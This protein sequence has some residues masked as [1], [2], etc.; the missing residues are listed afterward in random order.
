VGFCSAKKEILLK[1]SVRKIIQAVPVLVLLLGIA[2]IAHAVPIQPVSYDMPNG[3]GISVGGEYNYW[4]ENYT[5]SGDKTVDGAP[6]TGGLG[7]LT[8]GIIAT[9][10]WEWT[11]VSGNGQTQ[12]DLYVGWTW[13]DPTISF[14]FANKVNI[15]NVTF[16]VDDPGNGN[17][18]NPH[19]GGVA[20]PESFTI[21]GT[22]HTVNN[23]SPGSGPLAIKISDLGLDPVDVMTVTINRDLSSPYSFWVFVSEITFDDGVPTPVPE[24]ST[25]IL[26]GAGIAGFALL[27]R[28]R[29]RK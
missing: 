19:R 5:G 24:P 6:L 20:A 16:Y 18:G 10:S 22:T 27:R 9:K 14:Y 11:D 4:D 2:V 3:Y 8:D 23:S 13:G 15:N 29:Q 7:K 12:Q 26:F 28:S 17:N 25:F 21:N 1:Y